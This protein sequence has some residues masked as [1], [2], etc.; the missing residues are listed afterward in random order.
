[1]SLQQ[2]WHN[3][4]VATCT[5]LQNPTDPG[6]FKKNGPKSFVAMSPDGRFLNHQRPG[7]THVQIA[8][9]LVIRL[10]WSLE[11]RTHMRP[12]SVF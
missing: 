1:M 10:G 7:R 4:A 3:A 9:T 11:Q 6:M 12:L 5:A 8:A 2:L